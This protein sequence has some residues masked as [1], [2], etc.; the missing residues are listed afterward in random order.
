M[1]FHRTEHTKLITALQSI[2]LD[3]KDIELVAKLDYN[4]T[5]IIRTNNRESTPIVIKRGIRQVGI[6]YPIIF[7]AYS[8]N[9][10][11]EG[12][13]ELINV[14]GYTDDN[15]ILAKTLSTCRN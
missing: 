1:T 2:K 5:V 14:I 3:D 4:Q 13:Y 10:C 6:F 9:I 12:I 7:N 15:V 11:R 8:E